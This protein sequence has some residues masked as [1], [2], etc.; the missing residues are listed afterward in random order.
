M[1][2]DPSSVLVLPLASCVSS[3]R[4][5]DSVSSK[6]LIFQMG[7]V[8]PALPTSEGCENAGLGGGS[9]CLGADT[10]IVLRSAEKL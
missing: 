3:T 6:S 4:G 10:Q 7:I 9:S 8:T 5:P 2:G 1:R